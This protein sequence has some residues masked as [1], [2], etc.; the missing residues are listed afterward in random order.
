M[1]KV[2]VAA[3]LLGLAACSPDWLRQSTVTDIEVDGIHVAVSWLLIEDGQRDVYDI[4]VSR[5]HNP[6]GMPG[7][8]KLPATTARAAAARVMADRPCKSPELFGD[9]ALPQVTYSFRAICSR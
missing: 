6:A 8:A 1:T 7:Q 3:L 5:T 4:H 2:A 9:T